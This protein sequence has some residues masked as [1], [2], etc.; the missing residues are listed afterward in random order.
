MAMYLPRK[1]EISQARAEYATTP[2]K[3]LVLHA[4]KTRDKARITRYAVDHNRVPYNGLRL[5]GRI[6]YETN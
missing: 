4:K 2:R 1:R 5:S 3:L 6:W